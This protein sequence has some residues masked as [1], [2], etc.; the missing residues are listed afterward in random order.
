MGWSGDAY[1]PR[2]DYYKNMPSSIFDVWDPEKNNPEYLKNN[3]YLLEQYN[4]LKDFWLSSKANRQINW[5]RM[6]YV[7][8]ESEKAGGEAL[9]YQERRHNDQM[10]FA[11]NTA[12]NHEVNKEQKY[13]LGA[14]YNRTKGMHYKTMADL[15]GG[16]KFT[17]ID[18]FAA[19]DY[20]PGSIEA[21]NDM[22]NP[23]RQI[24]IDDKFGYN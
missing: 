23:N 9:Y 18:K 5:D 8:R 11:L 6:Y 2:P 1:D 17:D 19:S 12:F 14:S 7:N 22:R 13:T 3:P 10:V 24:G 15:L 20:G 16:S 21:Q 4:D